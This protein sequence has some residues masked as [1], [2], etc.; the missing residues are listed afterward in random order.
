MS[1]RVC[2]DEE[3]HD[4][5]DGCDDGQ[6]FA[7]DRKAFGRTAGASEALAVIGQ[8]AEVP[9]GQPA[10]LQFVLERGGEGGIFFVGRLSR[11]LRWRL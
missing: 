8:R 2:A 11:G 1:E 10:A 6:A 3:M 7:S 9:Q 5:P 4:E